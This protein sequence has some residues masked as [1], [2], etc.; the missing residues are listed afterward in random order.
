MTEVEEEKAPATPRSAGVASDPEAKERDGPVSI[1][2]LASAP[3]EPP[4]PSMSRKEREEIAKKRVGATLKG[5]R[6]ARLMGVGP[7]CAA[8]ESFRGADDSGEHVVLKLMVGNIAKHERARAMFLRGAYA[9]NR[10][11]HPRVVS[12]S[13]D[14][15]DDGAPFVVRPWVDA[16]TLE[17]VVLRS[18][19]GIEQ[20]QVLRIAEQ[21]LDA[22][23]IAHSHGIVHGAITPRNILVTPRGSVRLCDF[24]IPPGMGPRT[25]DEE[26]VL[27]T[28]RVGPFSAPERCGDSPKA[29]S[30]QTDL[31]MLAACL[32]F[33]ISK[34]MPRGKA[35]TPE[36][37][38]RTIAKPVREVAPKVS[39]HVAHVIDHA[40]SL[41]PEARFESAYAMLGDVR[42]AM[43]GRRPKLGDARRPVP[44]GSFSTIPLSTRDGGPTSS[45]RVGT[46]T[47]RSDFPPSGRG[48]GRQQWKGNV[49]LILAIA[50]LVGI[51]TFVMV[52]EKVEESRAQEQEELQQKQKKEEKPKPPLE[53]TP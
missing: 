12:V 40:L 17:Q 23:E 33:A 38:G 36:V 39:E 49:A 4:P 34:E 45:S 30:E 51:A 31:Y 24:S 5:W 6:L 13:S 50:L 18:E 37:L 53:S 44:S 48:E 3:D 11:T 46:T 21:V 2:K 14:G 52:R 9:S 10:F 15:T 28:R 35:D 1:R 42:R 7:I 19:G 22:L 32:Y 16:E 29:A 20:A 8:Y 41:E 26:D 27:A 25:S 47:L 43:A